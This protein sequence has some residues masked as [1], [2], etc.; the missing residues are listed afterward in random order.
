[1]IPTRSAISRARKMSW[2]VIRIAL[3]SS[4]SS[5]NNRRNSTPPFGSNPDVGSSSKIT[6]ASFM[7]AIA[8]P[9]RCRIP[10]LNPFTRRVN[11]SLSNPTR[12]NTRSYS[13]SFTLFFPPSF[14]K[15]SRFW[16]AVKFPYNITFSDTY[17]TCFFA[18]RGF[19]PMSTSQILTVPSV[20]SVKPRQTINVVVL[21][22]PLA[23][24]IQ[25]TSPGE[26]VRFSLLTANTPSSYCLLI[27][28]ISNILIA[29]LS[30]ETG[31]W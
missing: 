29:S 10:L 16:R 15:K 31:D 19:L 14:V 2:V 20:A 22:A 8:I 1:M 30:S 23:P 26:T 25:K 9:N 5:P 18:S 7:I 13:S 4:R 21:P 11:A 3:P 27:S 12:P 6:S 24:S 28:V 17:A